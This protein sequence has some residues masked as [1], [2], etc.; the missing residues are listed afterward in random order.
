MIELKSVVIYFLQYMIL[1]FFIIENIKN[2][3]VLEIEKIVWR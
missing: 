2:I 1:L 3:E